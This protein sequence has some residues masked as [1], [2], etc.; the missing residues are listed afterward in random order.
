LLL[1]IYKAPGT[2]VPSGFVSFGKFLV[3]KLRLGDEK[4]R[5]DL[6]DEVSL[7]YYRLERISSGR[8]DLSG[9][10]PMAVKSP[11]DVGNR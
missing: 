11:T 4:E 1:D 5:L 7:Q 9:G 3:R 6:E 8:I 2:F 10:E